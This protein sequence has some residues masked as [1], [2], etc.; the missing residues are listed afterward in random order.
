MEEREWRVAAAAVMV[1]AV[2]T[3]ALLAWAGAPQDPPAELVAVEGP[4]GSSAPGEPA[5]AVGPPETTG[6]LEPGEVITVHVAGAVARPGLVQLPPDARVADAVAAAGGV[7]EGAD[8]ASVN[9]AA[10]L[11]DGSQ[12]VVP[13]E[14]EPAVGESADRLVRVN[15]ADASELEALPGVGPVL[16]ERIVGHREANGPFAVVEDLLGVPGIGE[17]KLASLRDFVA[18]P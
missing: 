17:A 18:V 8:P 12:V 14:G 13:A 2:A 16:A 6:D 5:P 9:L 1:A 15:H 7:A 4:T 11:V 10:R 3:G